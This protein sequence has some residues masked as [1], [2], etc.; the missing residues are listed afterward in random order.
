M[1]FSIKI[2]NPIEEDSIIRIKIPNQQAIKLKSNVKC[3]K[4]IDN[5]KSIHPCESYLPNPTDEFVTLEMKE[6]CSRNQKQCN[7]GSI[8]TFIIEGF[9]NPSFI[10]NPLT[11]YSIE[12]Y[13]LIKSRNA[14]YDAINTNVFIEPPLKFS[15]V[16]AL[17]F[18]RN[19]LNFVGND[20]EYK[21]RLIFFIIF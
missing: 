2:N 10:V 13:T 3:Q 5:V 20:C 1:Q 21:I 15:G 8:L 14:I 19:G 6:F 16:S 17:S 9:K 12:I 11:N 4:S 7:S 18:E